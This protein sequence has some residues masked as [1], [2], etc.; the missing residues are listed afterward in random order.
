MPFADKL[1]ELR[2]KA[3]EGP[4]HVDP[5]DR[6]GMSWNNQ[7]C[8]EGKPLTVCFMA[9]EPRDNSGQQAAAELITYL[10]NHSAEIESLVR[11]ANLMLSH[12]GKVVVSS[13]EGTSFYADDVLRDALA[14][15]E[16][17]QCGDKS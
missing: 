11:A 2:E 9:H 6:P 7:I 10:R 4:W 15:L 1:R 5:D 16:K 8:V 3:T 17:E 13:S 14:A 12:C